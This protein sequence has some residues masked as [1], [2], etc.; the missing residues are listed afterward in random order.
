MKNDNNQFIYLIE[1]KPSQFPQSFCYES[2]NQTKID[3]R[4]YQ[5][6]WLNTFFN[7]IFWEFELLQW[8]LDTPL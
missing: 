6:K 1:L 2:F 7:R 4:F 5:D 3:I 8:W